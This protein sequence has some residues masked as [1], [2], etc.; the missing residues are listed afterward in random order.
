MH[1]L[2]GHTLSNYHPILGQKHNDIV[3]IMNNQSIFFSIYSTELKSVT[4]FFAIIMVKEYHNSFFVPK[5]I[6]TFAYSF[7]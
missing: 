4:I 2:L 5:N 3:Q 7:T 6:H 1:S